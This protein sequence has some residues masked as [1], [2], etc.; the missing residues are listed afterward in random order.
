MMPCEMMA[1]QRLAF[2]YERYQRSAGDARQG[3]PY[4]ELVDALV[5]RTRHDTAPTRAPR[6]RIGGTDRRPADAPCGADR[7]GLRT[8]A[9][10]WSDDR[11]HRAW[12]SAHRGHCRAS[13]SHGSC[14]TTAGSSVVKRPMTCGRSISVTRP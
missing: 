10:L 2:L 12:C 5:R 8:S 13:C 9:E 4:E 3:V 7:H 6:G 1:P 14:H 11:H